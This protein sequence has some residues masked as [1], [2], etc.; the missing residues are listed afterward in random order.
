MNPDRLPKPGQFGLLDG[1]KLPAEEVGT[2]AAFSSQLNLTAR[3]MLVTLS[4]PVETG[5]N[6][7]AEVFLM[8]ESKV[9]SNCL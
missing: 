5:M 6:T 3:G 1:S 4:A 9:L 2:N 8:L 7:F